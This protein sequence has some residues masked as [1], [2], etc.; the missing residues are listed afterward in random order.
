MAS[1]VNKKIVPVIISNA[2]QKNNKLNSAI[3]SQEL[4]IRTPFDTQFKDFYEKQKYGVDGDDRCRRI[5]IDGSNLARSHGKVAEIKRKNNNQEVFSII[6]IKIGNFLFFL[7]KI[8]MI[9][10]SGRGILE[11]GLSKGDRIF[12][13]E[14][15]RK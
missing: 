12:A 15:T 1:A 6:G 4:V 7:N 9:F 14:P 13:T 2:I 5:V 3:S 10:S 8:K 11:N